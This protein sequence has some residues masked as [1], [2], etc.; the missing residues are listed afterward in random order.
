MIVTSQL[1]DTHDRCSRRLA[2]EKTHEPRSISAVGLLYAAIEGGIVA[3][4]PCVGAIDATRAITARFDVQAGDLAP[5][6]VVRHIGFMAEVISLAMVRKFGGLKR[7]EPT[8]FGEHQWQ[9]NLFERKNGDLHRIFVVSHLD[10]DSLR[11]FAHSWGTVGELAALERDISLTAVVIGAQRAGR[12]HSH[13]TKCYQHPVQKSQ[14]RFSRRKGGKAEGFTEGWREVWREQTDI[15]AATWLDK[16]GA[17]EVLPDLIQ[18]RRVPYRAEDHRMVK[19]REDMFTILPQMESAS[20]DDPM[21]R[22]SCDEV[23][24][25]AC[26]FQP[27]CWSPTPVEM[28]DLDY[29]FRRRELD[30]QTPSEAPRQ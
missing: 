20:I 18:S 13:W 21:R 9:S 6:S 10:D 24:R 19:A 22:S 8:P 2:L 1:F 16:M 25:G 5:I 17:D 29:L 23:G 11:S 30:P 27:Y 7:I 12:R 26:V 15:S 4:D 3:P 14:L 28:D